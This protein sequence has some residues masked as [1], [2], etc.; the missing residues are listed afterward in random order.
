MNRYICSCK[1]F[2]FSSLGFNL[3]FKV[4]KNILPTNSTIITCTY[5]HSIKSCCR[6][7]LSGSS[8]PHRSAQ[9]VL[10]CCWTTANFKH[11]TAKVHLMMKN[12]LFYYYSLLGAKKLIAGVLL[13]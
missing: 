5:C 12:V 7:G 10:T 8:F 9:S 1:T 3:N 4:K 11:C 2:T 13:E 6:L